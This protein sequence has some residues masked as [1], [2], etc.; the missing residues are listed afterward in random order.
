MKSKTMGNLA[1]KIDD[2]FWVLSGVPGYISLDLRTS[3]RA[4]KMVKEEKK[5]EKE[6]KEKDQMDATETGDFKEVDNEDVANPK[7]EKKETKAEIKK[8]LSTINYSSFDGTDLGT[9]INDLCDGNE[10]LKLIFIA[11][12]T[13]TSKWI[14]YALYYM[15]DPDAKLVQVKDN[16]TKE[17]LNGI[18]NMFGFDKIYE[19][20]NIADIE[21]CD[22]AS[23]KFIVSS[24]YLLSIDG[25][26][27]KAKPYEAQMESRKEQFKAE[28]EHPE[29]EEEPVDFGSNS[30]IPNFVKD[31]DQTKI[32]HPVFFKKENMEEKWEKQ[33]TGISD[34]MFEK[35]EKNF[36]D[37]LNG[38]EYRYEMAETGMINL[39]IKRNIVS[40][41]AQD[42][43]TIDPGIVM[44]KGKFCILARIP[45]DTIFVSSDHKNI[46]T[47]VIGQKFYVLYPDE[48]QEV[49]MDYFYNNNIYR[50]VDM[51]NTEFL[52]DLDNNSYQ[53]VGKKLT[54]IINQLR[55]LDDGLSSDLP[56]FRFD[57]FES[58]DKFSII[59]DEKVISPLSATG[60][61]S[62]EITP[63]LRFEIN[64]DNV[65]QKI[66]DLSINY[67]I[68]KYGEL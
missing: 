39:F 16:R 49:A 25:L 4:R 67:K 27:E 31:E 14:Q 2:I 29:E 11:R 13:N 37:V 55:S 48:I 46:L 21:L 12:A 51:S 65:I 1:E 42:I 52:N 10:A 60:E 17:F 33:G 59:S 22:P 64:G 36:S 18:V 66:N 44:G 23:D 30:N 15:T 38:N 40:G 63:G 62:S 47:K 26:K 35:L 43:Y 6:L 24:P 19:S 34:E 9:K 56:R 58:A 20:A 61:T 3:A 41:F 53:N 57:S 28:A 45:N 8:A 50:Y 7:N 54:F 5:K 68:D 32:I